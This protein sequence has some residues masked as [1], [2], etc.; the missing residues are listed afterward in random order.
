MPIA[1]NSI[2]NSATANYPRYNLRSGEVREVD[3][4]PRS[5]SKDNDEE[6]PFGERASGYNNNCIIYDPQ[7]VTRDKLS[8]CC[9]RHAN[10]DHKSDSRGKEVINNYDV[11]TASRLGRYEERHV[12]ETEPATD[13]HNANADDRAITTD[14]TR[15]SHHHGSDTTEPSPRIRHVN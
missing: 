6:C 4:V 8:A 1:T 15:Q 9:S 3:V 13:T 10:S 14:Q 11:Y 2:T 5:E 7:Q 12:G